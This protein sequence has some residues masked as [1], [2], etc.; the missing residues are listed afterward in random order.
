MGRRA[1]YPIRS[2]R[3]SA[4][5]TPFVRRYNEADLIAVHTVMPK[6][7]AHVQLALSE[8]VRI[9]PYNPAWPSLFEAE[10]DH[11]LTC[12]PPGSI[13]RVEH[14][15]S[16]AVPG[17]AAKPIID[18]LVEVRSLQEAREQLAPIL[19]AQGYEFFWRPDWRDGVTPEYIWFIKRDAN[20][21]R[22]HHIHMLTP[23]SPEWERLLFRDYLR[24]HPDIAREYGK[25]KQTLASRASSR[26]AYATAKTR[27]IV[28]TT[29]AAQLWQAEQRQPQNRR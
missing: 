2:A 8:E 29:R 5:S 19:E 1:L 16:T 21:C 11:L 3:P 28:D 14:F 25:L 4:T 7:P 24:A 17:L 26:E 23:S 18:M 10:R 15:G 6:P 9:A 12:L 13:G 27:F 20:G 22:S